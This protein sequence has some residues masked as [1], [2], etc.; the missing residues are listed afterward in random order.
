M[1]QSKPRDTRLEVAAEERR[2]D[3]II[4]LIRKLGW[5]DLN[6]CHRRVRNSLALR[7]LADEID[8]VF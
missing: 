8:D 7:L 6:R 2:S 3:E 5:I 1:T 4:K